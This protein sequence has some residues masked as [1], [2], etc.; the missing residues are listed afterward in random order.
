[1][2][3]DRFSGIVPKENIIVVTLARYR[4]IV[5]EQIPELS[6]ENLLLEPHGRNTAPC[7]AFAA[8]E[9]LRRDPEGVFVATPSDLLI[10]DHKAFGEAIAKTTDYASSHKALIALGIVPSKA[11]TNFGYIQA[12]GGCDAIKSGNILSIK[13]FTEKPDTELAEI[14]V[15]S[16]EF[17][18]NTG[19]F[20]WRADVIKEEMEK[21][22]PEIALRFRDWPKYYGADEAQ[23]FLENA[24]S[25]CKRDSID[26]AV[27]ERTASAYVYPV[28]FSWADIGNW[29]TLY[30]HLEDKDNDGNAVSVYSK[31]LQQTS[32]CIVYSS[33]KR[34][35]IAINGLD[36]YAII[37]TGDILI[38]CPR[39]D[40]RLKEITSNIGLPDF[41]EFR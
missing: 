11:D 5:L 39:D 16:G 8:N 21:F 12:S 34:K 4:D 30:N 17:L 23:T 15:R 20:I 33:Q 31:L 32:N 36:N 40:K 18:W 2:T 22:C 26:Y 14:L 28:N 37:D 41:E 38:I 3:Y 9:I 29:D 10:S 1:M 7:I 27:M 24:Y 6:E 35:L 13:T 25:T 19:I